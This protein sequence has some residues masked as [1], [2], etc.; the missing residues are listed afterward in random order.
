MPAG[1]WPNPVQGGKSHPPRP[2]SRRLIGNLKSRG[3]GSDVF[4]FE[5]QGVNVVAEHFE[6]LSQAFPSFAYGILDVV[7][8]IGIEEAR[9]QVGWQG[10]MRFQNRTGETRRSI[11]KSPGVIAK[12]AIGEWSVRYGPT[13][14]YAPFLEYGTVHARPYPFMLPSADLVE[15]VLFSSVHAFIQLAVNGGDGAIG[16]GGGVMG[17]RALNDPRIKGSFTSLRSSLYSTAKAL[18]D[19]SV[20]G[21]RGMFG[22]LRAGMYSLAR[23]LGDVSSIMNRTISTRITNRL[24]GRVTG[25]IIGFGSHSLSYSRTY[26]AFPGGSGG[27][28]IYQRV[29][30]QFGVTTMHSQFGSLS[31]FLS[32]S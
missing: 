8:D 27:H 29:A 3:G 11:N 13:T 1:Q 17:G 16:F 18:G 26:S 10:D 25:R 32:G 20:I 12:P 23:G 9:E 4:L 5:L 6:V 31:G 19:I 21:G 7:S 24:G 28:R 30:G 15:A 14:F 22:P 2:Q